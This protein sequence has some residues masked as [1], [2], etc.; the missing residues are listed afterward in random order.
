MYLNDRFSSHNDRLTMVMMIATSFIWCVGNGD[1]FQRVRNNPVILFY[2]ELGSFTHHSC[3]VV[4]VVLL[5]GTPCLCS[6]QCKVLL[7]SESK[8]LFPFRFLQERSASGSEE[9]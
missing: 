5:M 9:D 7:N 6:L 4:F 8:S 3:Y 2:T 1:S